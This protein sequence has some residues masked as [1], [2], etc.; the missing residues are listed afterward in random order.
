VPGDSD[1]ADLACAGRPRSR[2]VPFPD[3]R[4]FQ[5]C[6]VLT[7]PRDGFRS[8]RYYWRFFSPDRPTTHSLPLFR[9][10]H[11]V[12]L[13]FRAMPAGLIT[14]H[15]QVIV[16]FPFRDVLKIFLTSTFS[17]TPLL[18]GSIF[19]LSPWRADL[20]VQ[21]CPRVSSLS[22]PSPPLDPASFFL[23]CL[24]LDPSREIFSC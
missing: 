7:V 6:P 23:N 16:S 15:G 5:A 18:F 17:S 21:I 2:F 12:P 14:R 13:F 9:S 22:A 1:V 19:H 10:A 11:R 3:V 8:C 4:A 20:G 24:D